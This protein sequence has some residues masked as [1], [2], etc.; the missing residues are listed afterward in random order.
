LTGEKAI[1]VAM[2]VDFPDSGNRMHH[3]YVCAR[4]FMSETGGS[5]GGACPT[6]PQN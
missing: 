4:W 6:P 3:R 5:G 2:R 1:M